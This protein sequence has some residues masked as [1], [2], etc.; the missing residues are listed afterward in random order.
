MNNKKRKR[1]VQDLIGMKFNEL[2][3][4]EYVGDYEELVYTINI[5]E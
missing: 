3:A 1:K 5:G 2:T 4:L